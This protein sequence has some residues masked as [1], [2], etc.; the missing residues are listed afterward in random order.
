MLSE[1]TAVGKYPIEAVNVMKRV[2]EATEANLPYGALLDARRARVR[3]IMQ[4]SISFAAC[5]VAFALK[6]GCIVANTRTGLTAQRVSRDRSPVPIIALT[7]D[8]PVM[9]RLSLLWGVYPHRVKKL[10]T[11]AEIFAAARAAARNSGTVA[12]GGKIVVVCGDPSTPGGMTDLLRVQS[13]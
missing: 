7:Y 12:E 8:E 6:A 11:T 13:I 3:G 1:E 2:A 9:N 10:S 4:E 5:D